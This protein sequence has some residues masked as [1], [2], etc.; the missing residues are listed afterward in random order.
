MVPPSQSPGERES[1]LHAAL[2][3]CLEAIEIGEAPDSRQMG[4]RYPE[5]SAELA[6]FF[7]GRAKVERVVAPLR[8]AVWAAAT[9]RPDTTEG[10]LALPTSLQPPGVL[11]DYELIEEIAAGGMGVVY[12][13]RQQSLGRLVALKMIRPDYAGSAAEIQRFRNEAQTVAE[14]DHP[15]IVPIYEVGEQAGQLY[16]TMKLIAGDSLAQRLSLYL[17]D[18]RA[19]ARLLVVIAQ[20]IHHAHQRGILHRDLKPSNILLDEDGQP[21]L[22]DFGLAKRLVGD[23]DLTQSGQLIGTP[24]YMAPEQTT[25]K[26]AAITTAT[27]VYGLGAVFYAVLTGRPPFRGETVLDTMA[28]VKDTN[29]QPPRQINAL[30][31]RDL[32]TICLKCLAKEP[33][34]RY[35][36]S[37][38]LAEDVQRWLDGEPIQARPVGWLGRWQ[39]WRA[40]NPML[41]SLVVALVGLVLVIITGLA[42]GIKLIA[43]RREAEQEQYQ[44]LLQR[45]QALR[46]LLYVADM[47]MAN[48]AWEQGETD[49]VRTLLARYDPEEGKEDLR[50]F[51]WCYLHRLIHQPPPQVLTGHEGDVY[52]VTY[53]P[54]GKE[55]ASV[56]KD[57]TVRFWDAAS[58]HATRTARVLTQEVNCVAYAPDGRT[59]ATAAD[60]GLVKVW[61]R[62]T[63]REVAVLRGHQGDVGAVAYSSDSHTLASGGADATVRLWDRNTGRELACFKENRGRIESLAFAPD[64]KSLAAIDRFGSV[65]KLAVWDV[66]MRHLKYHLDSVGPTRCVVFSQH[67]RFLAVGEVD[68]V[69]ILDARTG[70]PQAVWEGHRGA[71]QG[72]TFSPD[73]RLLVSAGDDGRVYLHDVGTGHMA[74]AHFVPQQRIWDVAI[75][76]DGQ[77]L[78][79]TTSGGSLLRWDLHGDRPGKA[80]VIAP[81]GTSIDLLAPDGRTAF[82]FAADK[83]VDL[84]DVASGRRLALKVS[85][86]PSFQPGLGSTPCLPHFSSD[87]RWAVLI[88]ED[89][90][91]RVWDSYTGKRL[92]GLFLDLGDNV[93][94]NYCIS[95][96]GRTVAVSNAKTVELWDLESGRKSAT[97]PYSAADPR[98]LAF[99]PDGKILATAPADATVQLWDLSTGSL[100]RTLVWPSSTWV[101]TM[102]F[103]ADGDAIAVGTRQGGLKLLDTNT[104]EE[105]CILG[106]HSQD[107]RSAAFSPDGR[108]LASASETTIKLWDLPTGL[109]LLTIR[110]QPKRV[111]SIA[112]TRDGGALLVTAGDVQSEVLIWPATPLDDLPGRRSK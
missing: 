110:T 99:S 94:L 1:R 11:G 53:G 50:S 10:R 29:P 51:V 13:A 78:A 108:T 82:G 79:A 71:V 39:R 37:L 85:P 58:G 81:P 73:D 41:S 74:G 45:E 33:G 26:Q 56:G 17:G 25:G 5:F 54:D 98:G 36:S 40:R 63:C 64:G 59:F 16:F 12:R 44:Q 38:A 32:E 62:A 21:H 2:A 100:R 46:R 31:A 66:A 92:H 14:L 8:Q 112:F 109:E 67:G 96:S 15:H 72:L 77:T 61:E 107:I 101:T 4:N 91:L 19:G 76:P 6:D 75:A 9:V 87:G 55:L 89:K 23:S 88:C 30:V 111:S 49:R 70:L 34:K 60:D 24:S 27:D 3:A 90:I 69:K 65:G 80:R 97:F 103:T 48:E 84:F 86:A 47:R 35:G 102:V 93:N 22:T 43:D 42:G 20:A 83:T 105:R 28:Q 57:G 104:G 7:A 95:P 18:P 68:R 106:G 52:C